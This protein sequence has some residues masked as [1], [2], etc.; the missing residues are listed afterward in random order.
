MEY[1]NLELFM[2]ENVEREEEVQVTIP[3]FSAPWKI[4]P[5]SAAE[6][7]AIRDKCTVTKLENGKLTSKL[8]RAKYENGLM[9]ASIVFPNLHNTTLQESWGCMG[10]EE[11]ITKMLRAGDYASLMHR[12]SDLSGFIPLEKEVES[13][14]N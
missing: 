3:G 2:R 6:E 9:I 1:D 10:A 7:T 4:R 13:A 8:D 5:L 11:L 14:K 12:I